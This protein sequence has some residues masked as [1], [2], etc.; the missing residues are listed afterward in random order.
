MS[1]I[2]GPIEKRD[3]LYGVKKPPVS[4][5]LGM[6]KL[7]ES[8]GWLS[9]AA[10]FFSQAA[11]KPDLSRMRD[12]AVK[13]GDAFLVQKTSRL[14][15][16]AEPPKDLFLEC[17]KNAEA[18]GKNRYALRVYDK[19]GLVDEAER[20]RALVA[21]DGDIVAEAMAQSTVFIPESEDEFAA[22]NSDE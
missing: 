3:I 10:D 16:E 9:D 4:E 11:A 7:F 14:M 12:D 13:V 8:L 17:A 2:P 6:A 19:L 22:S 15:G 1:Q 18:L 5:L 20:I 21:T